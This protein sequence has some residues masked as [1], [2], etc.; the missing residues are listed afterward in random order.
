[1][2]SD[3]LNIGSGQRRFDNDYG[4]VNIDC[5]SRPGQI[6]DL[7]CDVGRDVMPYGDGTMK[8]TV[9]HHVL[10][11]F[12][13][14]EA[15]KVLKECYRVLEPGGSLIITIPDILALAQRWISHQ[16]DDY[17]YIVNMMGAYAG[18]EGDSHKWH[19]TRTSL[20]E[21]LMKVDSWTKVVPFDWRPIEGSSIAKDWWIL[22]MEAIK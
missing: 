11:H 13:C 19:Y 5:V 15:D 4:W 21:T 3:K 2:N 17:I 8:I 20:K 7:I 9:L 10:E 1:M 12:R 6:P 22:G 14:G 16:I 18:E